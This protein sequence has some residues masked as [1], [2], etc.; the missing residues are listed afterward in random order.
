M[1]KAGK[2]YQRKEGIKQLLQA[3]ILGL[4]L[5][6]GSVIA[7]TL[8]LSSNLINLNSPEGRNLLLNSKFITDYF[9]L[10]IYFVTQNNLSYCGVAS[11]VMVFN[12]LSI[13]P[14]ESSEF[15]RFRMFTQNNFFS[16]P[17]TQAILTD[18]EVTRRGMTLEQLAKLLESYSVTIQI[19][20]GSDISLEEFR[21]RIVENLQEP[22]NYV[23]INYLRSVIGE[24]R[25]GHIS[26]IAAYNQETD[27]FLIL[28]VSRYKYPPVWIKVEELWQATQ[29]VD[30]TSGKSRGFVLISK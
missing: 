8:P 2:Y 12:A 19:Y 28:D 18:E 30:S 6:N 24:E 15:G 26:P 21:E 14:P 13:T 4:S 22:D 10:S 25:G 29:P 27:R 1:K 3:F 9:P 16:N 20:Y 5:I 7:Q 11:I 23:V 17:K